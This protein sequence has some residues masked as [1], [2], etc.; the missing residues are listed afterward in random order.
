ME[1]NIALHEKRSGYYCN[2]HDIMLMENLGI[3]SLVF[4]SLFLSLAMAYSV[5]SMVIEFWHF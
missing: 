4:F 3:F 2:R 5:Y 1:K